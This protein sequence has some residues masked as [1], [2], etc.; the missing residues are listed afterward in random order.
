MS[1]SLVALPVK[2]GWI[3]SWEQKYYDPD[4][5]L[6]P[7]GET[8]GPEVRDSPEV[9]GFL[10]EVSATPV[11]VDA[12]RG[13]GGGFGS[14]QAGLGECSDAEL[15]ARLAEAEHAARLAAA[16]ELALVAEF[17][18]RRS[19]S[20]WIGGRARLSGDEFV[21]DHLAVGL[22]VSLRSAERRVNEAESLRC[23]PRVLAALGAG[24]V[25]MP[26]VRAFLGEVA[27]LD[28]EHAELVEARVLDKVGAPWLAD[29]GSRTAAQLGELPFVDVAPLTA[30]ATPGQI[31][32]WTRSA[33]TKVDKD[34]LRTTA[35]K[36]ARD[37]KV[38]LIRGVGSG[39]SWFGSWMTQ[40]RAAAGWERVDTEARRRLNGQHTDPDADPCGDSAPLDGSPADR[41]PQSLDQIRAEVFY[42]LLMSTPE[43]AAPAPVNVAVLIAADGIASTPTLGPITA[44][45]LDGLR[46]LAQRSGGT[47]TT[48]TQTPVQCPGDHP[49]GGRDDPYIA[50]AGMRRTVQLRD[51]TCRHPG[52]TRPAQVCDLD[53]T[54]PWPQ[55]PTCPCNLACLCRHH[56]RLKT[57][58]PGWTLH[59]HGDGH[60]TWR[61][62]Y[63][64]Y[65]D[66]P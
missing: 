41:S 38:E 29:L 47:V 61:T 36:A 11:D 63:R 52:C 60:L 13:Q 7:A 22:G 32:R 31:T 62:P 49:N 30:N 35:E 42:D 43:G 5:L 10:A 9:A 24:L 40:E 48:T 58:D 15:I 64:D 51:Q 1:R 19:G 66:D 21:G 4:V 28:V 20:N 26:G 18:S 17:A 59:N 37:A 53:H 55:G 3:P 6:D 16:R 25:S 46:D 56:H 12:A 33:I 23:Y 65:P 45:T 50:P 54:I 39:M 34:A 44:P 27:G 2:A 57:H 14:W 8:L